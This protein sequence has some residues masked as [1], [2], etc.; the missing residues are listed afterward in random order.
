MKRAKSLAKNLG[1]VAILATA[2]GLS[3]CGKPDPSL[4]DVFKTEPVEIPMTALPIPKSPK[5]KQDSHLS[6]MTL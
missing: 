6:A 1:R 4:E 5:A 3:G 2:V